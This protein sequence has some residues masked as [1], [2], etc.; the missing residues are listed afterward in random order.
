M[1]FFSKQG[2]LVG[3]IA[4]LTMDLASAGLRQ[5]GLTASLTPA[6]IGR[7]FASVLRGQPI[8]ADIAQSPALPYE[9]GL[10]L[11]GHYAIGIF[12]AC[13]YFWIAS[14]FGW[15]ARHLGAMLCFGFCSNVFPWLL[16]FPAMGYGFFGLHGPVGTRLFVSSLSSHLLYGLGLWIGARFIAFPA[17]G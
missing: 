1:Y 9:M 14:R 13:L 12:L 6:V 7:W 2:V 8:H 11:V 16:M 4:T 17:R 10:A 15:P 5:L 3:V